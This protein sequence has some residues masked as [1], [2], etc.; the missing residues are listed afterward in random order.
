MG[1]S[2]KT[3]T[4][5]VRRVLSRSQAASRTGDSGITLTCTFLHRQRSN[6]KVI[7]SEHLLHNQKCSMVTFFFAV[8]DGPD[9]VPTLGTQSSMP[10]P[11]WRNAAEH[12]RFAHFSNI[13]RSPRYLARDRRSQDTQ[14]EKRGVDTGTAFPAEHLDTKVQH[15]ESRSRRTRIRLPPYHLRRSEPQVLH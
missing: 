7:V 12:V 15:H 4:R 8:P 6:L 5:G 3:R 14:A 10:S 9:I 11:R 1:P 13:F 2:L